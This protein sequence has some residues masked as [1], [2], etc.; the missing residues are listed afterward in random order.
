M[1]FFLAW[2][3]GEGIV[4]YRSSFQKG[5]QGGPPWPGQLMMSSLLFVILGIIAEGGPG[6]R[7]VALLLAWGFNVAAFLNLWTTT[8]TGTVTKTLN[9][10]VLPAQAQP[11]WWAKIPPIGTS[12]ILPTGTCSASSSSNG[13]TGQNDA[14][15][16]ENT[17]GG[18]GGCPPGRVDCP[19]AKPGSCGC[20][21]AG[22]SLVTPSAPTAGQLSNTAI[23]QV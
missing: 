7:R 8:S 19:G 11:G 20:T 3:V 5:S 4:I 18:V 9:G 13:Q 1:A 12:L 2:A 14:G 6:A 15:L 21:T 10:A 23:T 17:S 22:M 16:G